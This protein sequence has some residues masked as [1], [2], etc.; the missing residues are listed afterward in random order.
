M[1]SQDIC[2]D[3]I[4]DQNMQRI[5][6]S[7]ETLK[8]LLAAL[9]FTH[10][11]P[12]ERVLNAV[13]EEVEHLLRGAGAALEASEASE[14][15]HPWQLRAQQ[16]LRP[17]TCYFPREELLDFQ[18]RLGGSSLAGDPGI[19]RLLETLDHWVKRHEALEKRIGWLLHPTPVEALQGL[20][21]KA[22][23]DR[24]FHTISYDFR[25]EMKIFAVLYELRAVV[26][27]HHSTVFHSTDEF[28]QRSVRRILD[29]V[30]LF[31]NALEWGL[32]SHRG[33][34]CLERVNEIHGRYYLHDDAMRFVMS[35]IMFI[36]IEW[37][38]QFGWRRFTE[39]E[40]L[41]WFHAFVKMGR[42][43]NIQGMSDDYD[44]MYQWYLDY[45]QRNAQFHPSKRQLFDRITVQVLA[46]YPEK[47][48]PVLL[49]AIL[50]GMDD[51][52]RITTG[53]PEPPAQVFEAMKAVF[54]SVG[55]L[56]NALPRGPWL[57][58][59]QSTSIYPHGYRLNEMGVPQRSQQF[60][61]LCPFSGGK[62][63]DKPV[64]ELPVDGNQGFPSNMLPLSKEEDAELRELPFYSREEIARHNT[65]EDLWV[66]MEGYVYDVTP[67]LKVHPGGR[68]VMLRLA[69]QDA[70]E[71]FARSGHSAETQVY[72]LNFR[73]GRVLESTDTVH[74]PSAPE[75]APAGADD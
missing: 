13:K 26:S 72:K 29:T 15:S 30:L 58:S 50:A 75:A 46:E 53:Y 62:V 42:A 65:E 61:S 10:D 45:S 57:R 40:R 35:G 56:G 23:C 18:R 41:G 3:L 11:T 14:A 44:E 59:L 54:F 5:T 64:E 22:D 9:S 51:V 33:S 38:Q 27:A 16:I 31:A 7:E 63:L 66:I 67:F 21:P 52:Y 71:A 34:V 19:Q 60:P 73:I 74:T 43:M 55:H 2:V 70:T 28:N 36:P 48:R 20:D 24:I 4:N 6:Q 17:N 39:V 37:N 49:T 69:G 12:R 8:G 32:D 25:A 1:F 47:L 68:K